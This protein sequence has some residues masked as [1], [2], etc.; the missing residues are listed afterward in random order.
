MPCLCVCVCVCVCVHECVVGVNR[1]ICVGHLQRLK[2]GIRF[3]VAGVTNG[4]ESSD[5][6]VANQIGIL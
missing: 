4:Y 3:S 6:G 2:E 1:F 5:M